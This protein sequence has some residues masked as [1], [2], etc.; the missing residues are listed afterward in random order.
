[1]DGK[2]SFENSQIGIMSVGFIAAFISG[3]FACSW[4]ITLV[5]KSKLSYFAI[6]CFIIGVIAIA[7]AIFK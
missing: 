5:K 4:M 1:M 3:L 6:Y 2:I 7:F